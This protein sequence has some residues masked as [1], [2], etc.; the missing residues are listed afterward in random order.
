MN[1]Q[2]TQNESIRLLV[3]MTALRADTYVVKSVTI[4]LS[5]S[6]DVMGNLQNAGMQLTTER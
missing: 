1:A 4:K 5:V 2:E 3:Y 6:T